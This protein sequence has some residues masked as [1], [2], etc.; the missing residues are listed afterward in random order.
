MVWHNRGPSNDLE[1]AMP[2]IHISRQHDLAPD[3]ARAQVEK[4]AAQLQQELDA[5]YHWD[6]DTLRFNRTGANGYIAVKPDSIEV[7]VKLG[8]L[9]GA[10]KGKVEQ[11]IND[12]L[13]ESLA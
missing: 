7:E 6:G 4:L 9:L 3:Q 10:F 12:H 2:T 8:M 13:D 5:S 1:A 11:A